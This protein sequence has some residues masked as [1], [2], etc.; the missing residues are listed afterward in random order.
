MFLKG[1]PSIS[2]EEA[3]ALQAQG[4]C[5]GID[6]GTTHSA[7]AVLQVSLHEIYLYSMHIR[8]RLEMDGKE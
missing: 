5:V 8:T 7:V 4:A 6:L 3:A 2:A 1:V